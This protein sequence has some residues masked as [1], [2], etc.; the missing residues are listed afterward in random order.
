[1]YNELS[2]TGAGAKISLINDN[3]IGYYL[4][5][6]DMVLSGAETIL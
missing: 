6:V 4:E 5:K 1:M 2:V 3:E